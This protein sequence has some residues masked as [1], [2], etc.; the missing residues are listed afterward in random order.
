M[1]PLINKNATKVITA[2]PDNEVL[3][4]EWL[5]QNVE[6]VATERYQ[7]TYRK[8]W[9]MGTARFGPKF[10]AAYFTALRSADAGKLGL[11]ELLANLH[12]ASARHNGTRSLQ[13]SFATKLL[14]MRN[15]QL[16]I[17]DSH[18]AQFYFFQL[19]KADR[20]LQPRV[21]GCVDFYNFLVREYARVLR[22]GLLTNT[23]EEFRRR[24][25][26]QYLTDE[27]IIDFLIWAFVSS[28]KG[29]ALLRSEIVYE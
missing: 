18:V 16:P 8:Y 14:H 29:G 12:D 3:T 23:I 27:K 1:Y 28:A 5:L 13:F 21:D 11:R 4:Y 7:A 15:P 22:D 2:V 25:K 20:K 9:A 6:Q 26:P 24:L 17:Y 19:P 10:Y